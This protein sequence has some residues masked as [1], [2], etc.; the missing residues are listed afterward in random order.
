MGE[1]YAAYHPDL[2]RRIALKVVHAVL[3]VVSSIAA[4][5]AWRS[6]HPVAD[7]PVPSDRV[8]AAA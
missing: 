8:S 2:D 6:V 3:A 5:A 1:V 7:R 4:V